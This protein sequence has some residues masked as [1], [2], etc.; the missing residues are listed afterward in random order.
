MMG[1]VMLAMPDGGR[2]EVQASIV[3]GYAWHRQVNEH[4]EPIGGWA[5]THAASGRALLFTIDDIVARL[6]AET[7]AMWLPSA[8]E[9]RHHDPLIVARSAV[10]LLADARQT[11]ATME[12]P[13]IST[14]D[15]R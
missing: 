8:D 1:P 9:V 6:A 4:G 11:Y 14:Q 7:L 10:R 15:E 2:L 13:S 3:A 5:V 12:R